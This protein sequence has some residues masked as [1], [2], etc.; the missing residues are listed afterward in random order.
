[1]SGRR[2]PCRLSTKELPAG[3]V[4]DRVNLISTAFMDESGAWSWGKAPYDRHH[5]AP[6]VYRQPADGVEVSNPEEVEDVDEV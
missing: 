4:A 2:D 5:P 3:K 1:M 6:K